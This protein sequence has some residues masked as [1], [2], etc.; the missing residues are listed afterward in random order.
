MYA[1][2]RYENE[3]YIIDSFHEEPI[4]KNGSALAEL[5][6][7][8]SKSLKVIKTKN[9]STDYIIINSIESNV[10]L[11]CDLPKQRKFIPQVAKKVSGKRIIQ[12]FR[13]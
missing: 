4:K 3:K 5:Q 11:N 10:I 2:L 9:F 13:R 12:S 6:C 1:L 8:I 7:P